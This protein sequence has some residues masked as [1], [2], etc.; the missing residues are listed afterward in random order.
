MI[1]VVSNH[2]NPPKVE[3]TA[4]V[5]KKMIKIPPI[6][7]IEEAEGP[8]PEPDPEELPAEA[9]ELPRIKIKMNERLIRINTSNILFFLS[10]QTRVYS[11]SA[12]SIMAEK[13]ME[14][15]RR[16]AKRRTLPPKRTPRE[17]REDAIVLVFGSS[18]LKK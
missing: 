8:G 10:Y 14:T 7:D 3:R 1:V 6:E 2:Q 18:K 16:R 15:R 12:W 17:D 4:P 9:A 11:P 13:K 5:A